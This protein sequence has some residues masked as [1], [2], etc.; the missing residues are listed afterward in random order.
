VCVCVCG[1][2]DVGVAYIAAVFTIES[3]FPI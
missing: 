2:G 1:W 3:K